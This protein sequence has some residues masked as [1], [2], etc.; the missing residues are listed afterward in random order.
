MRVHAVFTPLCVLAVGWS[1][2]IAR[3]RKINLKRPPNRC[4]ELRQGIR[5]VK[6]EEHWIEGL[7]VSDIARRQKK[8]VYTV[9]IFS[10]RGKGNS[11]EDKRNGSCQLT[12]L[13]RECVPKRA[14]RVERD[15]SLGVHLPRGQAGMHAASSTSSL[16]SV[17]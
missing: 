12:G 7:A 16:G 9:N 1:V 14:R 4:Y 11:R 13:L 15:V 8:R 10:D 17:P 3:T 2:N 5:R 6:W